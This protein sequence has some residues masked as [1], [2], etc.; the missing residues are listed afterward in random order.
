VTGE[1][2]DPALGADTLM[3]NSDRCA[4]EVTNRDSTVRGR[5]RKTGRL[6]PMIL[7]LRKSKRDSLHSGEPWLRPTLF[8]A[9]D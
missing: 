3:W 8:S 4:K 2:A 6:H 5:A 9:V 7:T 1:E